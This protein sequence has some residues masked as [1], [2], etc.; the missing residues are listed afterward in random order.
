[1]P[2]PQ[3]VK[4]SS[5]ILLNL[6]GLLAG[7]ETNIMTSPEETKVYFVRRSEYE[8]PLGHKVV[9][10]DN[11]NLLEWFQEHW[12]S[13]E[14]IAP[15]RIENIP[16]MYH[17]DLEPEDIERGFLHPWESEDI[18]KYTCPPDRRAAP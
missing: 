6:Y 13:E 3:V 14:L 11:K 12:L 7:A 8:L 15:L 5:L 18:D 9:E 4:Q 2:H 17:A 1:M 16:K 10:F